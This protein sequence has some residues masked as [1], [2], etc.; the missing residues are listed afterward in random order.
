[1]YETYIHILFLLLPLVSFS[2]MAC[3][4]FHSCQNVPFEA[5]Q[6]MDIELVCVKKEPEVSVELELVDNVTN[7]LEDD[8]TQPIAVCVKTEKQVCTEES[9]EVQPGLVCVKTE[10][11]EVCLEMEL[12]ECVKTELGEAAEKLGTAS[13]QTGLYTDHEIK[14]ELVLGPEEWHRPQVLPL[15]GPTLFSKWPSSSPS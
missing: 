13:P 3:I 6:T 7:P 15:P 11:K 2:N 1:M 12:K 4:S 10:P 8:E 5:A 9:C 14:N